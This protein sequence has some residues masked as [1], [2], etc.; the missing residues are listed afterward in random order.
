L[1]EFEGFYTVEE[2]HE[3]G[4]H[5]PTIHRL[6]R[7]GPSKVLYSERTKKRVELYRHDIVLQMEGAPDFER[8][9]EDAAKRSK[10]RA[11]DLIRDARETQVVIRP[12]PRQHLQDAALKHYNN[13][14]HR[15]S[16]RLPI[17]IPPGFWETIIVDYL[18]AE[19]GSV[20]EWDYYR[21][22]T[23]P[24]I[25]EIKTEK[26]LGAISSAYPFL[27]EECRTRLAAMREAAMRRT[28]ARQP[29]TAEQPDA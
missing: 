16:I 11:L 18:V 20:F 4:W 13:K 6:F 19:H 3:R 22:N 15:D 29:V 1:T 12:M 27:E 5:Y 23:I 2:L 17:I 28:Q 8:V 10:A 21:K 26:I 7:S 9:Q 25:E 24:K 14:R